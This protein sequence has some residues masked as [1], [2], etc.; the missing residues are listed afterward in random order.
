MK[1]PNKEGSFF[2]GKE[3]NIMANPIEAGISINPEAQKA[4]MQREA[5]QAPSVQIGRETVVILPSID[6]LPT[7]MPGE[8]PAR[9]PNPAGIWYPS[10]IRPEKVVFDWPG[11]DRKQKGPGRY[12]DNKKQKPEPGIFTIRGKSRTKEMD[13]RERNLSDRRGGREWRGHKGY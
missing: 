1:L 6:Q 7:E 3:V 9:E 10:Q 2:L 4:A 12:S 5:V 11:G 13:N 8:A